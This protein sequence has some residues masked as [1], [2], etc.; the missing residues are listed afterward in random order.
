[1]TF[2]PT[3]CYPPRTNNSRPLLPLIW[4]WG[5]GTN[6]T[7]RTY[8]PDGAMVV[9]FIYIDFGMKILILETFWWNLFLKKYFYR[10]ILVQNDFDK[11]ILPNTFLTKYF[12]QKYFRQKY[13]WQQYFFGKGFDFPSHA[14]ALLSTPNIQ[15]PPLLFE[16]EGGRNKRRTNSR[17]GR[18]HV[19]S[20]L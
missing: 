3:P 5:G 9:P 11:N 18:I 14:H 19:L 13:F 16:V 4:S 7:K 8:R 1:M 15:L 6:E 10:N 20:L 2:P 12:C 17:T